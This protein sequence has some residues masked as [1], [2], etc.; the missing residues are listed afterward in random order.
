MTTTTQTEEPTEPEEGER[1]FH[2]HMWVNGTSLHFII[3]SGSQNNLISTKVVKWLCMPTTPHP[4]P[5]NIGWLH[6]G[7]DLH[8]IQRCRLSY[9]INPF[10]DEVICDVSPMEVCEVLLGQHRCGSIVSFMSLDLVVSL[11]LWG[12]KSK[13]YWR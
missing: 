2:S 11:L 9:G 7:R 13:E 1:L 3:D 12:V 4:Q 5:Y 6:R 10:K 8:V